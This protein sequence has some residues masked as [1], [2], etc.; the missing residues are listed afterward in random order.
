MLVRDVMKK[1]IFTISP[2]ATIREALKLMNE[3]SVRFLVTEKMNPNDVYGIITFTDILRSI[4]AEEGDVDLLNVYD[5]YAKPALTISGEAHVKYAAKMM[6]N[7]KVKR[8]LVVD[9]NQLQGVITMDD[10]VK[11]IMTKIEE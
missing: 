7:F 9:N 6:I 2:L 10:I 8:I 11:T 3:K 1:E 5:I 4:V